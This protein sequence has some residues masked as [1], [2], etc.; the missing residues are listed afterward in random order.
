MPLATA[1]A[2]TPLSDPEELPDPGR[3]RDFL[4]SCFGHL[5]SWSARRAPQQLALLE[6]LRGLLEV[7]AVPCFRESP[8]RV[9]TCVLCERWQEEKGTLCRTARSDPTDVLLRRPARRA[10][11]RSVFFGMALL[12]LLLAL[13]HANAAAA[14]SGRGSKPHIL[15]VVV[16]GAA[17]LP[18]VRPSSGLP[19]SSGLRQP[20]A[21]PPVLTWCNAQTSAGT[22]WAGTTRKCSRRTATSSS[23]RA[24]SSTGTTS[25]CVSEPRG[26]R[27]VFFQASEKRLRTDCSPTRSAFH[28][29]RFP[30]H[31][32]QIILSNDGAVPDW[33]VPKEMTMLPEK[34]KEA[35][36]ECAER[37]CAQRT[38]TR[39]R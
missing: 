34:M 15:M 27:L 4:A 23:P 39:S 36:C 9:Q 25:T 20:W 26:A 35:G 8:A 32:N 6:P 5:S 7:P 19:A 10:V 17:P 33:G 14:A 16:D 2:T 30:Y 29:G 37:R 12:K 21:A 24:S 11:L 28:S 13:A 1:A 18:F 31:V 38:C 22:M 3:G